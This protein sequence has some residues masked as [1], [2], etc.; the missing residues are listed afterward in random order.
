MSKK[1]FAFTV[2]TDICP[3]LLWQN[4]GR[5]NIWDDNGGH[6][7][8]LAQHP[9]QVNKVLLLG[10]SY[11]FTTR[12]LLRSKMSSRIWQRRSTRIWFLI[13]INRGSNAALKFYR[14]YMGL[15]NGPE[16]GNFLWHSLDLCLLLGHKI[17][18]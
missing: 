2:T 8:P 16:H 7:A 5:T 13:T 18:T 10:W 6:L 11:L 12:I 4:N 14:K 9:R 17:L 1:R 3:N 15:Q